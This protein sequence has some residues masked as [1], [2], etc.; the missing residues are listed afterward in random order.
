MRQKVCTKCNKLKCDPEDFYAHP[1]IDGQTTT[2][3]K[4]CKREYSRAYGKKRPASLKRLQNTLAKQRNVGLYESQA[5]VRTGERA[6]RV[7]KQSVKRTNLIREFYAN[8]PEGMTVDHV[9][10]LQGRNISGLHVVENLQYLT[11]EENS[12]KGFSFK[13]DWE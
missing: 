9:V 5:S 7:V 6:K 4:D 13:T 10:P 3:C 1:K 12:S 2:H 11:K 8:R